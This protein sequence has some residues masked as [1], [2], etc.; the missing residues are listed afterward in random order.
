MHG[1]APGSGAPKGNRNALKNGYHTRAMI[2]QRRQM[3]KLYRE[4]KSFLEDL[5]I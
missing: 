5:E 1:G 4:S 2:E 3:R